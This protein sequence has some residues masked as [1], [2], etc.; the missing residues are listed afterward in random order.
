MNLTDEEID[1]ALIALRHYAATVRGK[2]KGAHSSE[3]GYLSRRALQ[4]ELLIQRLE[5]PSPPERCTD[6]GGAHH[7]REC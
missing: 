3:V 4:S 7:H 2:L 5:M 6:C 1:T